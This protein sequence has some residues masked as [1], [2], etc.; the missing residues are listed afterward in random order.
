MA[1]Q[2]HVDAFINRLPAEERSIL[3]LRLE[4]KTYEEIA[5]LTG[6]SIGRVRGKISRI[7]MRWDSFCRRTDH[8]PASPHDGGREEP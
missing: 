6:L 4:E 5:A 1:D 7:R 8:P 2:E 3:T